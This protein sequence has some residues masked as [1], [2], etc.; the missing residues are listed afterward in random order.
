MIAKKEKMN[1]NRKGHPLIIHCQFTIGFGQG[2]PAPTMVVGIITP[3]DFLQGEVIEVIKALV[4]ASLCAQ[5]AQDAVLP[6][7]LGFAPHL[8]DDDPEPLQEGATA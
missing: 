7:H 3:D 1:A 6:R 5:D 2:D 4:A 8:Q